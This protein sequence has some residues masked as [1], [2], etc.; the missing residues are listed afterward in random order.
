MVLELFPVDQQKPC[1][2]FSAPALADVHGPLPR[3]P[4]SDPNTETVKNGHAAR[5]FPPDLNSPAG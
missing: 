5:R 2:G 1:E 3:R 4:L